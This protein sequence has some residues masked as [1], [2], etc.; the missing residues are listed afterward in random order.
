[1]NAKLNALLATALIATATIATD[2]DAKKLSTHPVKNIVL[3]H[4][5]FVDE[6]SWQP[7]AQILQKDGFHVTLVKNPLTS[8]DDDV[9]ATKEA[10]KAQ[11]GAAI[12][13]GH[14]WG[15]AVITQAGNEPNVKALVYVSAFAPN[16]GESLSGLA[17]SGPATDGAKAIKVDKKGFLS[18]DQKAF[19]AVVTGDLPAQIGEQLAANQLPLNHVAFEAKLTEAAWKTKPTYF[20]ISTQDKVIAPDAQ[21]FFAKRMNAATIEVPG[22]HASLVSHAKEVALEIERAAAAAH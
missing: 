21:H 8:L 3:V 19:S 2:A 9:A 7:V 18:I 12:L 6:T 5:A 20:V 17:A 14:S 15:G 1:M 16:V 4:G 13:V 11:K 10:L 22:S